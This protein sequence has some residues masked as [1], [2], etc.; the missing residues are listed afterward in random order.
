MYRHRMFCKIRIWLREK[1]K[2]QNDVWTNVSLFVH[3]IF[4]EGYTG[5]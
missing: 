3:K 1:S 5:N 4:L 2:L